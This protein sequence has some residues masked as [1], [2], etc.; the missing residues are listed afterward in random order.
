MLGDI[1]E[2]S[3]KKE[4]ASVYYSRIV[5]QYPLSPLVGD[6]KG[7]LV[8]FGVPVPQADPKAL[9]WMQAEAAAPRKKQS[10]LN[11]PMTLVRTGPNRELIV[12]SQTGPPQMEPDS[13]STSVTDILTGGG[14]TQIGAGGGNGAT[15]NTAVVEIATPGSGASGGST[16]ETGDK[17]DPAPGATADPNASPSTGGAPENPAADSPASAASGTTGSTDSNANTNSDPN[18]KPANATTDPKKE[19]TSKKKKGLKKIIP[20]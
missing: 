19:S 9:A 20:W 5:K 16:V 11:K 15:G 7:K 18:A 6:A 12:A 10:L 1:F 14:K 2:K 13:D 17:G 4:I 8:A 3:E